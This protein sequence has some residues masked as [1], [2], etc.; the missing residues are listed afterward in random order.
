MGAARDVFGRR[1]VQHF[2]LQSLVRDLS[3]FAR[4]FL[5]HLSSS[6]ELSLE[7]QRV[8]PLPLAGSLCCMPRLADALTSRQ[9]GTF[10]IHIYMIHLCMVQHAMRANA[11]GQFH[12]WECTASAHSHTH[13]HAQADASAKQE[14][15]RKQLTRVH[16]GHVLQR[17]LDLGSLSTGERRRVA[18]ALTLAHLRLLQARGR[19]TSNVLVLDEVHTNLDG[20]GIE[21]VV[22]LLRRLPQ[23]TVLMVGQANSDLIDLADHQLEVVK[24][25][26]AGC[27]LHA[28]F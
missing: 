10:K 26:G 2:Q 18:L 28:L 16:D 21:R 4:T 12:L 3:T 17:D 1:G 7:M 13:P 20:E 15:I 19:C 8:R 25:A 24:R 27:S 6:F 23:T 5:E 14:A 22:A 11:R 9:Q